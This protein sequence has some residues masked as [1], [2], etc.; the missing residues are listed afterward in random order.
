MLKIIFIIF[1]FSIPSFARQAIS[2]NRYQ[3]LSGVRKQKESMQFWDK[4]FSGEDYLYGKTP[5]K[6]LSENYGYIPLASK[7]LDVGMGEGRNTVF[8]ARKGY[9]V[10]G[11]DISAIAVRKAR[12]LAAEHGIRINA[13]VSSM[14]G[15]KG[16]NN[17]FDAILVFYYVDRALNEKLV[18][19]LKPGGILIYESH[20]KKQ[21]TVTG[22][23]KYEDKYLLKELELLKMFPDLRVLKFEEPLHQKEFTSSIILQKPMS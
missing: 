8:L 18:K 17:S 1:V 5:A 20:T 22:S 12:R 19:W 4:K 13:V 11:V 7:V 21:K 10:T 23:E 16:E 15:F 14:E 6:F 2:G 3:L 9:N